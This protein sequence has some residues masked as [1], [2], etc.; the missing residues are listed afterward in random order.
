MKKANEKRVQELKVIDK[1][2]DQADKDR[3]AE[4]AKLQAAIDERNEEIE[5]LNSKLDA[6]EGNVQSYLEV[7]EKGATKAWSDAEKARNGIN[8]ASRE[9]RSRITKRLAE[10]EAMFDRVEVATPKSLQT[11]PPPPPPPSEEQ[12]LQK[13]L[14]D[15][16]EVSE[17][18]GVLL[19]SNEDRL[20]DDVVARKD[21]LNR[22]ENSQKAVQY[23]NSRDGS[24]TPRSGGGGRSSS[25]KALL[26][27][28]NAAD[29]SRRSG[30]GSESAPPQPVDEARVP[31]DLKDRYSFVGNAPAT[32]EKEPPPQPVDEARVPSDLKDRYSFVGNASATPEKE[33]PPQPGDEARGT[34]DA[35]AALDGVPELE[36]DKTPGALKGGVQRPKVQVRKMAAKKRAAG[37][38]S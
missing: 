1:R 14:Q 16:M 34:S 30:S 18:R 6:M 2:L 26:D 33:P 32:P 5:Q 38:S 4:V 27:Q 31:S 36:P 35:Q 23:A 8:Q 11:P 9:A 17:E 28:L 20:P 19:D 7:S 15:T 24:S 21:Q 13:Q 3:E 25:A 22:R 12:L 10:L 29:S 37:R